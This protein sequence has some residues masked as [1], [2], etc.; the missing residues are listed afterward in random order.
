MSQKL[1]VNELKWVDDIPE[2]NEDFI[3]SYN[4][5]SNTGC[6]LDVDVE[7]PENLHS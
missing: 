3:K 6:F 4:D 1:R 5:E 7:Y 2:F